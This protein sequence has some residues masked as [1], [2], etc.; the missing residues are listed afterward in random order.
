MKFSVLPL[1]FFAVLLNTG[2]Q[3]LLKAGM[4]RIGHF[5]FVVSKLFTIGTQIFL[6]P[7]VLIG[8]CSYVVSVAVWLLVLSRVDVS[9]AYPMISLGYVF[10]AIT[11]YYLFDET[12]SITRM[13]GIIIILCGVYLVARSA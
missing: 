11:A 13:A 6:N 7:F 9:F 3:L 2:A 5:D 10:S 12:L 1:I 8:L 4:N